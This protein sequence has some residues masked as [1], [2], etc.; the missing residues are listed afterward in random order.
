M[1]NI[2]VDRSS[3]SFKKTIADIMFSVISSKT[4]VNILFLLFYFTIL[5]PPLSKGAETAST[6]ISVIPTSF[7]IIAIWLTI[8]RRFF[9]INS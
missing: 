9:S 1:L 6:I 4:T 2:S 7:I 3:E 8:T 5:I